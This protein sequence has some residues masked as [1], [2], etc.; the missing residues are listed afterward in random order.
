MAT[1]SFQSESTMTRPCC[2][3]TRL[4]WSGSTTNR[5]K[6]PF[7]APPRSLTHRD[8]GD[9]GPCRAELLQ[10]GAKVGQPLRLVEVV[11]RAHLGLVVGAADD[12]DGTR[13]G[14]LGVRGPAVAR[15][16]ELRR[17]PQPLRGKRRRPLVGRQA[18]PPRLAA[19]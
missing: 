17:H 12:L 13:R 6:S 2:M 4:Y 9:V 10:P 18:A 1:R 3:K 16:R 5:E 7:T 19:D 8:H 11:E 14:Q 15:G